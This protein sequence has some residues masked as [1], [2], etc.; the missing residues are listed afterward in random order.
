MIP[1][2]LAVFFNAPWQY[3]SRGSSWGQPC[4]LL[5]TRLLTIQFHTYYSTT[6]TIQKI[7]YFYAHMY[8]HSSESPVISYSLWSRECC[9]IKSNTI[10]KNSH[11]S[12]FLKSVRISKLTLVPT[13]FPPVDH[14]ISL[15][16]G[17]LLNISD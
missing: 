1:V 4:F 5:N 14:M 11:N 13:K 15:R 2:S 16:V 7:R 9:E 17:F 3:R 6:N 10:Q 8:Y 12:L